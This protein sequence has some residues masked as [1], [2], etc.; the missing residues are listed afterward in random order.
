[1]AEFERVLVATAGGQGAAAGRNGECGRG[2]TQMNA[3]QEEERI[4]TDAGGYT[5]GAGFLLHS[6]PRRGGD[7]GAVVAALGVAGR[8]LGLDY[9]IVVACDALSDRTAEVARVGEHR[10]VEVDHRQISKT[11]NAAAAGRAE[12][13][14]SLSMA[15]RSRR[16]VGEAGAGGLGCWERWAGDHRCGLTGRCGCTRG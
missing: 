4:W 16:S 5:R 15:T 13:C 10:V 3:D 8:E 14:S 2:R 11:R 6:G 9:E 7:D 12:M 1:M